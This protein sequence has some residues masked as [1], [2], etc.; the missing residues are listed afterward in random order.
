MDEIPQF[1]NVLIGEMSLIGPRPIVKKELVEYGD[2]L[3]EFLSVKPGALGL[4]Q[5][6]GRSNIG[7]P[8]RCDVELQYVENASYWY[9]IKIF[10]ACC[11]SILKKDGAF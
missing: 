5:A 8:E 1:L 10:C 3:E 7:Y 4:W 2:R 11:I 9:D 6:T